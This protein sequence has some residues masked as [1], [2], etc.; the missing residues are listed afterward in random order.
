MVLLKFWISSSFVFIS[1][2]IKANFDCS[3]FVFSWSSF[4]SSNDLTISDSSFLK[5]VIFCWLSF[6][7]LM[8][9]SSFVFKALNWLDVFVFIFL[10]SFN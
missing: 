10:F 9:E 2:W 5:F 4:V 6:R 3:D 7:V 8:A 1:D